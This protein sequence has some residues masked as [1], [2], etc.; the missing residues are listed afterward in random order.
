[1][2]LR[3]LKWSAFIVALVLSY[4]IA[5][6]VS[7]TVPRRV[8]QQFY[9]TLHA[10]SSGPLATTACADNTGGNGISA[11]CSID[12]GG[13]DLLIFTYSSFVTSSVTPMDSKSNTWTCKTLMITNAYAK[14]MCYAWSGGGGFSVGMSHTMTASL[15]SSFM[16]ATFSAWSGSKTSGDP[17]DQEA[18]DTNGVGSPTSGVVT[19]T[20]TGGANDLFVTSGVGHGTTEFDAATVDSPFTLA[21]R[22]VYVGGSSLGDQVW[23]ATGTGSTTATW[24]FSATFY[25]IDML[26]FLP[27]AAAA[28]KP[29]RL[30]LLGVGC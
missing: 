17:F 21:S 28:P 26:A 4:V 15:N 14:R 29:C 7:L 1:M 24:H 5:A 10:W 20:P 19:I 2:R 6:S 9:A 25:N 3:P 27:G 12:S 8:V 11:T 13:A 30:L 18:T 23:Y 22:Q 16:G